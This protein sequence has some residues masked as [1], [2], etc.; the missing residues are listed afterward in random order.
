[1][2]KINICFWNKSLV[3]R[4]LIVTESNL[5]ISFETTAPLRIATFKWQFADEP[6]NEL[7]N[8]LHFSTHN[9]KLQTLCG[10]RW[11][12]IVVKA[13][14]PH[15]CPACKSQTKWWVALIKSYNTTELNK[16]IWWVRSKRCEWLLRGTFLD[17]DTSTHWILQ[18]FHTHTHTHTHTLCL[19]YMYTRQT[20]ATKA[21]TSVVEV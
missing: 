3:T 5:W 8:Q 20:N 17:H 13:F 21:C 19:I 2:T 10:K 15:I 9:K 6:W 4:M 18:Y 1:M 14:R 12:W 11:F 16:L 7:R